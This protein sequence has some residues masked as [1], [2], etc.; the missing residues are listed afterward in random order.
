MN[1]SVG[2]PELRLPGI[3]LTHAL[4]LLKQGIVSSYHHVSPKYL[5]LYLDEFVSRFNARDLE[6]GD[7]VEKVLEG[8]VTNGRA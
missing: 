1:F 6:N 2:W 7:Y 4:T 3:I 8:C 5:P